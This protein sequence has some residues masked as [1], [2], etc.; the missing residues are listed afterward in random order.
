MI[1]TTSYLMTTRQGLFISILKME[2]AEQVQGLCPHTLAKTVDIADMK[3]ERSC[4]LK[5]ENN[6][7]SKMQ[8][9]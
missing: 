7:G 2:Q 9:L 3:K 1:L 8:I 4:R 6:A 5:G